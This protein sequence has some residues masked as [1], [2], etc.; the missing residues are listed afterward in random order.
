MYLY[1]II[2]RLEDIAPLSLCEDWDNSGL[3]FGNVKKDIKR[4]IVT[5]DVTCN[6]VKQACDNN[7]ELI[8][9]H[10]P[11][12]FENVK[13]L[14]YGSLFSDKL[15]TLI[16]NDIAV[17]CMHTNYDACEGGV[18]DVLSSLIG[19]EA[20]ENICAEVPIGKMGFVEEKSFALFADYVIENSR[21]FL[22]IY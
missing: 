21:L 19:L 9:A 6:V 2:R 22:L 18:N 15:C 20:V 11:L 8:I 4:I 3:C 5:L 12:I 14:A 1:D 10:H 17:Y 7:F 16:K 13:T